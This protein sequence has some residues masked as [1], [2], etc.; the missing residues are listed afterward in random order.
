V[1]NVAFHNYSLK[2]IENSKFLNIEYEIDIQFSLE[3]RDEEDNIVLVKRIEE[4]GDNYRHMPIDYYRADYLLG[5]DFS[6]KSIKGKFE[7]H[8]RKFIYNITEDSS[9]A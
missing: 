7:N 5:D 4:N 9:I 8:G 6:I 3:D 2:N 1:Y